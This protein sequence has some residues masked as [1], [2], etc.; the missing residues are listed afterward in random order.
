MI[1]SH[2][3]RRVCA[4]VI[5]EGKFRK[6]NHRITYKHKNMHT[7][8]IACFPEHSTH[9]KKTVLQHQGPKQVQRGER[10]KVF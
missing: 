5:P 10:E 6:S 8:S 1:D 2:K 7:S 9:Y 3:D 4:I